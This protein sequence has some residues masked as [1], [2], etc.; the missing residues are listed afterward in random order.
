MYHSEQFELMAPD[1][2]RSCAASEIS[3]T[4]KELIGPLIGFHVLW[5]S[6]AAFERVGPQRRPGVLCM[7]G[8]LPPKFLLLY[9]YTLRG[10][11]GDPWG[12]RGLGG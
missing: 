2:S 12:S 11:A 7:L 8:C 9:L 4:K 6:V 3:S 1:S 5:G 10:T